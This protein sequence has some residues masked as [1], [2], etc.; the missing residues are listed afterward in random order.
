[1]VATLVLVP[2]VVLVLPE[3]FV[4]PPPLLTALWSVP[5]LLLP[6]LLLPLPDVLATSPEPPPQAVSVAS[7][8]LVNAIL[9]ERL[10]MILLYKIYSYTL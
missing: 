6:V 10:F 4:V 1:M 7:R 9:I 2:G 8:V 5:E 3:L